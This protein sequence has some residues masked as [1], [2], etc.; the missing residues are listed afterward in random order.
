MDDIR[1]SKIA[2]AKL[3]VHQIVLNLLL[4]EMITHL[5]K[6]VMWLLDILE[7]TYITNSLNIPRNSYCFNSKDL[8]HFKKD[9]FGEDKIEKSEMLCVCMFFF[10]KYVL[11]FWTFTEWECI[12]VLIFFKEVANPTCWLLKQVTCIL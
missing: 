10:F 1:R 11:S 6:N 9:N 7:S 3:P 8:G 2:T 12:S 4:K 5:Q